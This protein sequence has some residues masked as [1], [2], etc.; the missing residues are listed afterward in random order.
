[1]G[2]VPVVLVCPDEGLH[3]LGRNQGHSMPH[4][5]EFSSPEAR[6]STGF[7]GDPAGREVTDGGGKILPADLLLHN[8]MPFV[9]KPHKVKHR[10]C[11]VDAECRNLHGASSFC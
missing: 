2:V 3:V 1:M 11:Q 4:R 8:L 6:R 10:F 7:H 9:I 5:L